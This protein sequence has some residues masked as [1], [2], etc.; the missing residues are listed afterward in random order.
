MNGY[1]QW[2]SINIY[3]SLEP[4]VKMKPNKLLVARIMISIH[5][6]RGRDVKLKSTR[7]QFVDDILLKRNYDSHLWPAS[8][9]AYDTRYQDFHSTTSLR[10]KDA[11]PLHSVTI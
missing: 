8:I 6:Q 2:K 10:K 4:I 7:Y 9:L 5:A 11:M 3:S 1:L